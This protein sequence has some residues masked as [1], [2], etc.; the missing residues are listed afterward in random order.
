MSLT[1]N[2]KQF[3]HLTREKR[4]L[5][6][7]AKE[8]GRLVDEVERK[9]VEQMIDAGVESTR[10]DGMTVYRK[11]RTTTKWAEGVDKEAVI[12]QMLE[13]GDGRLLGFNYPSLVSFAKEHTNE[14][15]G[16]VEL[17]EYLQ[18]VLEVGELAELGARN[19]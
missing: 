16:E 13:N 11:R 19:S 14:E 9:L 3:V 15:T 18:G 10:I 5:D 17:P 6:A 4:R 2:L 12:A 8:V 1:E 7:E